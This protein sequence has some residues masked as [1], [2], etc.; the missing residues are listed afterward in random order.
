MKLIISVFILFYILDANA[1]INGEKLK[2]DIPIVSIH[3]KN[4]SHVCSGV[5]LNSK[6]IMTAAHC[7][8]DKKKWKGFSL[9]IDKIMNSEN[10]KLEIVVQTIIAHP[11]FEYS[12]L[13]NSHDV[14]VIKV[15][16]RISFKYFPQLYSGKVLSG[17]GLFY[18]CGRKNNSKKSRECSQ[19]E[20]EYSLILG[21]I[22][23]FGF[24]NDKERN[25]I[26]VSVAPNDSGGI[27][28]DSKLNEIVGVVWGTWSPLLFKYDLKTPSFG[29]PLTDKV[30]LD[31]ILTHI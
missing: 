4:G 7:L 13:G 31:F 29:T 26:N 19:G 14:G 27:I 25:G 23:S 15:E 10:K 16:G 17:K 22:V 5:F 9:E 30:N 21:Q 12:K 18:A 1:L 3:F 6:T 11:Q 28:I 8:S 24:S 2:E 20:N